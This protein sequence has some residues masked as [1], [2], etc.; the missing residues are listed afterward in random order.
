MSVVPHT[1]RPNQADVELSAR[2]RWV[3]LLG[4]ASQLAH[5]IANTNF[6]PKGL[7]GD[8]AAIA[9]AIL[10]GDEVG[11]PP[12]QALAKIAVIDGKPAIAAEAQRALI[13]AAGHNIWFEDMT[14]TKVTWCGRRVD[15]G[16]E[17]RITWT[18]DDA[19]RAK[20]AGKDNWTKFPRAMLSARASADLA[21]AVFADV[22]GGLAAVEELEDAAAPPGEPEPEASTQRPASSRRRRAT[23]PT[24]PV[25]TPAPPSAPDDAP[26]PPLPE[27]VEAASEEQ[28][29]KLF[30]MFNERGIGDRDE[31]LAWC[32]ERLERTIGS[33]LDLTAAEASTLIDALDQMSAA[34]R[35]TTRAP[36]APAPPGPDPPAPT[37]LPDPP[38]P[39]ETDEPPEPWSEDHATAPDAGDPAAQEAIADSEVNPGQ[40]TLEVADPEEAR[41]R[42]VTPE[43]VDIL[44]HQRREAGVDDAWMRDQLNRLGLDVTGRV[45]RAVLLRMSQA[46][47]RELGSALNAAIDR[48]NP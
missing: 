36:A 25:I 23:R 27:E 14:T 33:S 44:Q 21:R 18:L 37:Q 4:E 8:E 42:D 35:P 48:R 17:Q 12:M 31:R 13:I 39:E 2:H 40:T 45:T 5:A 26:G 28:R 3:V 47:A 1:R 19:R 43:R 24:P 41:L 6:V 22:I 38:L 10:Y 20:L 15:T 11:L 32:N 29:R 9:A 46:Q 30:A 34:E 16:V 7:R